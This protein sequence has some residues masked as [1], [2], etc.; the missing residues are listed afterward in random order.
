MFLSRLQKQLKLHRKMLSLILTLI[1]FCGTFLGANYGF[2]EVKASNAIAEGIWG[3]N[4][5]WEYDGST[6]TVH[7]QGRM[8]D[9]PI[10]WKD[11]TYT[12]HVPWPR[13]VRKIVIDEGITHI[14][15]ANFSTY[16]QKLE[17][18]VL[19]NSLTSIGN[20]AFIDNKKLS[21]INLPPPTLSLL[22]T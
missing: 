12:I 10:I 13:D 20:S 1:L 14:G 11:Y 7:G 15:K 5:T 9:A 21:V 4:I 3:D 19:P 16:F 17:T 2:S 18:V 6:L 8:K 22:A